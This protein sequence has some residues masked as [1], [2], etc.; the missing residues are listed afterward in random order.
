MKRNLEMIA[1]VP[2]V[3]WLGKLSLLGGIIG[4]LLYFLFPAVKPVVPWV[5]NY[6][7]YQ[8]YE[9]FSRLMVAPLLLMAAGW[10]GVLYVLVGNGPKAAQIPFIGIISTIMGT[11][12]EFWL[13][14]ALG[15]VGALTYAY[16]FLIIGSW[17]LDIGALI[18][19]FF[20]LRYRIKPPYISILM[21]LAIPIDLGLFFFMRNSIFVMEIIFALV[22]GWWLHDS[23]VTN[24]VNTSSFQD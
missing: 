4:A 5:A 3:R 24:W 19:G 11:T 22:I 2:R 7:D 20:I 16:I 18:V 15:I 17:F 9:L 1:S 13:F 12:A 21:L 6:Q 23:R 10:I 8:S 14:P